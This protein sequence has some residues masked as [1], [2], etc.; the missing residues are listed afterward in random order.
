MQIFYKVIL[1]VE[2]VPVSLR[3]LQYEYRLQLVVQ[4]QHFV[5]QVTER[6]HVQTQT[7]SADYQ[8][9]LSGM[10][11]II[12]PTFFFQFPYLLTLW[13]KPL[14]TAVNKSVIK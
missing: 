11:K 9:Y 8:I 7:P 12:T 4:V 1:L 14:K 2:M 13:N 10:I 6:K 3:R 5:K